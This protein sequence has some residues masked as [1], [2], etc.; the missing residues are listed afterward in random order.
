VLLGTSRINLSLRFVAL[1]SFDSFGSSFRRFLLCT[2]H[3]RMLAI[4]VH[5]G[6]FAKD[7]FRTM[8]VDWYAISGRMSLPA[9]C[10]VMLPHVR[11]VFLWIY[12][13]LFLLLHPS[14]WCFFR[15]L[16]VFLSTFA[17]ESL[18]A[19]SQRV[20][21]PCIVLVWPCSPWSNL[22]SSS[23]L[24]VCPERLFSARY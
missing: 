1:R 20:A 24:P 15:P 18:I 2:V 10:A 8:F 5:P 21:E 13:F 9:H 3:E 7:W 11:I 4:D 16:V 22:I 19:S 14:F 17:C 23:A 6:E 12:G